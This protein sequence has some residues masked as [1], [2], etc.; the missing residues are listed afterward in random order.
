MHSPRRR[1]IGEVVFCLLLALF[2]A[3]MLW[4]AYTISGFSSLTSAGS[5]PLFATAVMLVTGL[6]N[7]RQSLRDSTTPT[8]DGESAARKFLREL[9]PPVLLAFTAATAT[10]MLLLDKLG[11]VVA[12]YLFLVVSMA[13][14]GSRRWLLNLLVSALTLAAI[15]VVFQMAFSV[16]LPKGKW[17]A[18]VI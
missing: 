9:T 6:I 13:L 10:Y 11:F 16:V 12:S 17:L 5:F 4:A 1:P 15:Y 8:L 14:L 7:V 2:S 18:G 3:F